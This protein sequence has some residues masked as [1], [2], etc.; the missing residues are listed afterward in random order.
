MALRADLNIGSVVGQIFLIEPDN[1]DS[2]WNQAVRAKFSPGGFDFTLGYINPV[3]EPDAVIGDFAY[4][5]SGVG[6]HGEVLYCWEG[7]RRGDKDDI[8]NYLVGCDYSFSSGYYLALEYY[9]NDEGFENMDDVKRYVASHSNLI[10]P[11]ITKWMQQGGAMR[12]HLFLRGTK[13]GILQG[14]NGSLMMIYTLSDGS[15]IA[16]PQLEYELNQNAI[17]LLKG[18]LSLGSGAVDRIYFQL[19]PASLLE[20]R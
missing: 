16:Q 18:N 1:P 12:D 14:V 5:L 15:A 10:V 8:F 3:S 11:S 9:H 13:K 6:L 20:S 4:S 7:N 19:S 2:G 17:L